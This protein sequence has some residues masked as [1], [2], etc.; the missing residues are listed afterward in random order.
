MSDMIFSPQQIVSI[1][2]QDI[3][4]LPGD[5]ITCG[6]SSDAIDMQPGQTIEI[7]IDGVGRLQNQYIG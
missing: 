4:L 1:I 3:K 7:N 6:T 2:S 5:V